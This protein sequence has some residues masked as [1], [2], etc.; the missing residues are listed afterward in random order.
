MAEEIITPT[1]PQSTEP[2]QTRTNERVTELSDKV[3]TTA[4]ALKAEQDK[5][6]TLERK[7]AFAEGFIDVLSTTPSAKDHKADIE[8]KVMGGY[9]V[10][11]AT[12]AVLGAAGK[13]GG[14]APPPANPAG[15]SAPNV[16]TQTGN[17]TAGEMTQAERREQLSKDITWN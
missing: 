7:A 9:T 5:N 16:I 15:G 13:L 3:K 4:E 14:I 8:A 10:Q 1:T 2:E 12:Y 17:K 6:L 11:D